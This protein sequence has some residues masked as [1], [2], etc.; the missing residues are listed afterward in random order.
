MDRGELIRIVVD[1]YTILK[2]P[3]YLKDRRAA[4]ADIKHPSV[5]L[6]S[7]TDHI[8]HKSIKYRYA[9]RVIYIML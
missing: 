4:A 5:C 7:S 6:Q 9:L 1:I 2:I 8:A 3:I